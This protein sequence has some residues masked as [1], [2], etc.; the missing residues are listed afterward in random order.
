[1]LA[2]A[3]LF[4]AAATAVPVHVVKGTV[5][6][7]KTHAAVFGASVSLPNGKRIAVTGRNG[8]FR[9]E[10]A[11]PWPPSLI[12]AAPG[13]GERSIDLPHVPG[14]VSLKE[15]ALSPA[16]RIHAVL[17]PVF[18]SEDLHW[19]LYRTVSGKTTSKRGEGQFARG[20][21]DILV[22]GLDADN[23]LLLI[24]GEGPL[25]QIAKRVSPKPGDLLELPIV[26][27][28]D[29]LNLSVVSGKAPMAGAK[30]RFSTHDFEWSGTVTCDE[31]GKSSVE[32]W[33]E[34]DFWASLL[35]KGKVAFARVAHL[36][37]DTGTISWTFEV[38]AHRVKGRVVDSSTQKSLADVDVSITGTAD[39]DG[40]IDGLRTRTDSEGRFEFSAIREGSHTLRAYR[41]GYRYDRVQTFEITPDDA[42]WEGEIALDPLGERPSIIV[43]DD[44]GAPLAG[45][46]MF[47]ASAEGMLLLEHT[48][49]TG[50]IA[51]PPERSGIAFAVPRSGSFGFTSIAA[52][53][54]SDV[55]IR[56][57]RPSGILDVVSQA[58]TGEPISNV[59]FLIRV[60]GTWIP[61][62]V[63]GRFITLHA[64]PPRTDAEGRAHLESLPAGLYEFWP[65]RTADEMMALKAGH[66]AQA[67]ATVIVGDTPQIVTLT[68]R[69][70]PSS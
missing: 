36:R 28:P 1:M 62:E 56:V 59:Y 39:P 25:Q 31:S 8:Q 52:D 63:F 17:P 13:H 23:Y 2:L 69:K 24:S 19:T 45:V 46:D 64:L 41:K 27:T 14:D 29:V 11:A 5:V 40:G 4:L 47:L 58:T 21:A 33:Q 68:F 61:P 16:A 22:D 48:D 43:L 9:A 18:G 50:R 37:S 6:D 30:I 10:I 66:P 70:K 38:P 67:P 32:V 44:A 12:V 20:R 60:N 55:T 15:I 35:D 7:S 42:D 49:E 51:I 65:V 34:D 57:P 53:Q 54:S 26:I 3:A